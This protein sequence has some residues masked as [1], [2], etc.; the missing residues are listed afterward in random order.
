MRRRP[1]PDWLRWPVGV[2]VWSAFGLA[3]WLVIHR[4]AQVGSPVLVGL[5]TAAI[6]VL[7]VTLL[8]VRRNR[9]IYRIKQR[10]RQVVVTTGPPLADRLGRQLVIAPATGRASEVVL[11]VTEDGR[12]TYEPAGVDL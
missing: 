12:K 6:L 10:R 8:W 7:L 5:A 11:R 3:W 4:H 2:V 9:R 1:A